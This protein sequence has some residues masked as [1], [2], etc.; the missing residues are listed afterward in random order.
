MD[1]QSSC[2][3]KF[4]VTALENRNFRGFLC[5]GKISQSVHVFP[6][7][8]GKKKTNLHGPEYYQQCYIK[9]H[10]VPLNSILFR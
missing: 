7:E 1:Y 4:N 8:G 9:T 5:I 3:L 2:F 10:S 6:V